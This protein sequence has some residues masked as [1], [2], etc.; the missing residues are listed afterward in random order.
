[1][2][3]EHDAPWPRAF[4][5]NPRNSRDRIARA[6]IHEQRLG[7]HIQRHKERGAQPPRRDRGLSRDEIV[8]AAIAIAD[9]EGPDAVSMRRIARELRAGV[10]SLYWYVQS[11]EELLD[12]M[13]DTLQEENRLPEPSGDWRAD[14]TVFAHDARASL[15]RHPWVMDFIGGRPPSGPNDA[16]NLER[17]LAILDGLGLDI[18]KTFSILMSIG[19]YVLGGVLRE[20]QEM[21]AEQERA[22][23]DAAKT[24]EER[25]AEEEEVRAWLVSSGEYP[26]IIKVIDQDFDPD[27]AETRDER[28]DFGLECLLDGLAMQVPGTGCR[29]P[30]LGS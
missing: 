21:R 10:M 26:H 11:K 24:D 18:R 4:R 1:M 17:M 30:G 2:A 6:A 23:A 19:T 25:A 5:P 14:L 15:L 27:S 9:A 29:P 22:E 20:V 16:R 7:E 28:F 8:R 3:E 13:L 12:L